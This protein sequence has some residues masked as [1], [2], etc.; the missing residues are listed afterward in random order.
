M[1]NVKQ[2]KEEIMNELMGTDN[3]M[4]IEEVRNGAEISIMLPLPPEASSEI[5]KFEVI[6][7]NGKATQIRLGE[8]VAVSWSVYEALK[9]GRYH[10]VNILI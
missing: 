5:E 4:S 10:D 8:P 7:I 1:A 2:S 9:N 6:I 3:E